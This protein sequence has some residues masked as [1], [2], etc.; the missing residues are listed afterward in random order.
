MVTDKQTGTRKRQTW[1]TG[2]P[3]GGSQP[4]SPPHCGG[5]MTFSVT[6]CFLLP[7]ISFVAVDF[8]SRRATEPH[9]F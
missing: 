6:L 1:N 7:L 3:W 2:H 4:S 5:V 8:I 9:K